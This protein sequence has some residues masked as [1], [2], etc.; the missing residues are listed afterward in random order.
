MRRFEADTLEE[1]YSIASKE[2]ECSITN[3]EI[4]V[5]QNPTSGF[6]GMFKKRAIIVAN[7]IKQEREP[8]PKE[9]EVAKKEKPQEKPK[10]LEPLKEQELKKSEVKVE[11]SSSKESQNI[12]KVNI[13][14][15]SILDN[16]YAN[17]NQKDIALEIEDE[18]NR[19]FSF[20]CFDIDRVTVERDSRLEN[21][22]IIKFDGRDAAL[23]I[24]KEGYRYKAISYMLFNWINPKYGF[25]I[26]LEIAEFLK[27]QE[28]MIKSYLAPLI[29]EI[30]V[31]GYGQTKPLDGVLAHIALKELREAFP[32]KY[33]VTKSNE[34]GIKYVIVSDFKKHY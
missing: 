30:K 4:E 27:N 29:E 12:S 1:A 31:N 9:S 3:L 25:M 18:L 11:D 28:E 15:D 6:L 8:K 20:G 17:S 26:R 7:C 23:L 2:F 24:G 5:I 21:T 33:V 34:N 16:F 10:A 13:E 19:L 22:L 14:N 32:N